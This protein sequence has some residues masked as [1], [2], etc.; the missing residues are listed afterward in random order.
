LRA[1]TP[2]GSKVWTIART[3]S[4]SPTVA[5]EISGLVDLLDDLAG[6]DQFGARQHLPRLVKKMIVERDPIA[7]ETVEI[8]PVH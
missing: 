1:A 8:G 2:E 7:F 4:T 3:F 5:E 6:G